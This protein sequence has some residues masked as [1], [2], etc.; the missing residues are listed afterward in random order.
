MVPMTDAV[1]GV[2]DDDDAFGDADD[3]N[4]QNECHLNVDSIAREKSCARLW[5]LKLESSV[6]LCSTNGRTTNGTL[7][8]RRRTFVFQFD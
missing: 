8:M 4:A 2:D 7:E 3:R 5:H 6:Q 1:A